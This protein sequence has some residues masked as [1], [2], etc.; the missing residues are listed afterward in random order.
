M[1]TLL[2]RLGKTAFRR[3]PLFLA[4]WLVA[5]VGVGTVAATMSKPMTDAFSIPGIPSEKAA[6]LQAE[7][8]PD[9]R[10]RLRPGH[11]QRRGR[12]T[13]GPHPGRA[14]VPP[15]QVDDLVADLADAPADAGDARRWP[16]RSTPPTQ[17][18]Q[19]VDA[20]DEGRHA[21]AAGRGQRRGAVCR[22]QP[23]G[24]VG[25][26]TC[27]FDVDTPADVEPAT[28]GRAC[29]RRLD[30]AREDGLHGR[31][32]RRRHAGAACE[33]GGASELI[34]IGIALR[35]PPPDLR[36]AGR[37]RAADPHRDHR[38]RPRHDRHHRADRVHRHRLEHPDAGH[39]DR[40]GGRHRLR[41]VHPGPLP[42]RA[43]AHRRPRG[44]GRRR[45]RHRRL[46][47]GLR[48]PDRAHRAGRA[49]RSSGSRS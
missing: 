4:G 35:R 22:C 1:A 3:W 14:G 27:N 8:F 28:P 33:P 18:D 42:H 39:D 40:P 15:G 6:D 23:D 36:L 48:R 9:V 49:G 26:I 19:L 29:R 21:E 41:A 37:R 47:G 5:V 24:R 20:A 43:A 25:T 11:R 32:Q 12:R 44:G 31:G 10:R 2:Y 13:R 34:G 16:T 7:L 17:Q 30:Q 46:R 38:R 45:G